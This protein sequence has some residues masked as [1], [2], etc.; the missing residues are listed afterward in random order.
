MN[1]LRVQ[2]RDQ[3]IRTPAVASTIAQFAMQAML[4]VSAIWFWRSVLASARDAPWSAAGALILMG[5]V[6]CLV[7]ALLV[8]APR[9]LYF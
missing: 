8:F 3:T 2:L 7:A 1:A 6:V 5:K 9:L 4:L